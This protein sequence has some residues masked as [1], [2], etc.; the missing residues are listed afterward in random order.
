MDKEKFL[1][2]IYDKVKNY[3]SLRNANFDGYNLG[4]YVEGDIIVDFFD[5]N[6]HYDISRKDYFVN[7]LECIV[8]NCTDKTESEVIEDIKKYI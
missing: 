7:N 8:I 2:N 3:V 1:N 5:S 6:N 4:I